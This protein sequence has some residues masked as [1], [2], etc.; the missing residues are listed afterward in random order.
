M[1][2]AIWIAMGCKYNSRYTVEAQD[3]QDSKWVFSLPGEYPSS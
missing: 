1:N 2:D 3:D